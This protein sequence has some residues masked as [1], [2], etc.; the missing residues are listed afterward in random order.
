MER[1]DGEEVNLVENEAETASAE[2]DVAEEAVSEE[3]AETADSAD[4]GDG[5]QSEAVSDEPIPAE[6][7]ESTT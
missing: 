1:R 4:T 3:V 6:S 2:S 5:E 7:V